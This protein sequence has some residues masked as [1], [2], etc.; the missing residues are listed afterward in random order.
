MVTWGGRKPSGRYMTD[1][2]GQLQSIDTGEIYCE[3][4]DEKPVERV[5]NGTWLFETDTGK[6]YLFAE[7]S[8]KWFEWGG[9]GE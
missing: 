8:A 7:S 9:G 6:V 4:T 1:A 2:G 5:A 3:S